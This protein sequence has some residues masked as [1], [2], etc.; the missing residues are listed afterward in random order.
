MPYLASLPP[1]RTLWHHRV[2]PC[3]VA[4][5]GMHHA[6]AQPAAPT[7]SPAGSLPAIEV[8]GQAARGAAA[9]YSTTTLEAQDIEDTHP[10]HPQDLLRAVPGMNVQRYQ[11]SGVGDAIVMRGFGAGGHGGD[12][13]VVLD[14]IPL[15]EAMSHADG[16][17]DL[18]VIVPLEI[19]R[20]TV[21]KGPV[22]ALHGNFNRAGLLAFETRKH[23]SYRS[24]DLR[25]GTYGLWD[26]QAALGWQPGDGES[27]NIAAQ[28]Y[29]SDGFRVQSRQ[30]RSTLAARWSKA[31]TPDLEL[32][33]SGRLHQANGDSPGYVTAA[34]WA[35][36]PYGKDPR[37]QNDGTTKDFASL[38]AD[39]RYTLAPEVTWLGF[40]YTT[41]QRFTRWFSRPVNASTWRQREEHYDRSV[42]GAGTSL[43]GRLATAITPLHWVAG[44]EAL[45]ES[46]DYLYV[47]G[48]QQRMR[49]NPA[50]NDRRSRLHSLSA[51][52][53]VDAPVHPLLQA[54]AGLRWDRFTGDCTRNGP[55]TGTD[56]CG[57][58][59]RMAHASPKLGVRSQVAPGV[60][61]RAS[62]SEGFALPNA[63]AKYAL[64]AAQL[65]PT[66]FR[67]TELGAQ[68]K[69][70]AGWVLDVAAYRLDASG[71]IRTVAP[72][73]YENYGATRRTG[74]EA[75]ALWALHPAVDL[76]LAWGSAA[77]RVLQHGNAALVGKAV[78][79]VPR[80]TATASLAWRPAPAWEGTLT[81]R[82]VGAYAVNADH[83]VRADGY[84][85][86]DLGV[87]YR[88]PARG[89]RV[90]AL[91]SN[92]ADR[93]YATSSA[94]IGGIQVFAPGAP[95]SATVGVQAT[96]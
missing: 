28:H 88:L 52:A 92:L 70:R 17:V 15:N 79:G 30:Q 67:Q 64:G 55:E 62:A 10:S 74:V 33:L 21:Y 4:L 1:A 83:S 3:L 59:A 75:S 49:L 26:A 22:S 82:R 16:Y 43:N 76:Q 60:L 85:T 58:L 11:L 46:T 39:L 66:V 9:A 80:S 68:L 47:D 5:A 72:G 95:R 86:L 45:R 41:Q 40:A 61:L 23:G 8:K 12:V 73:V 38:R 13:G 81:W 27:V 69:P 2:A 35:T 37:A 77:S 48:L 29:R 20:L 93:R 90:Y 63:F 78:A 42:L 91:L 53:E 89:T 84:T 71:E 96:F 34:Q 51:F 44:I 54:S 25:T 36:D 65:D 56:P 6:G 19:D 32:A 31:V 7:P 18:G 57:P 24:L 94:V 14:G 50:I 87:H